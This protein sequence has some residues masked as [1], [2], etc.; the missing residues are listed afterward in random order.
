[1]HSSRSRPKTYGRQ[2][3]LLQDNLQDTNPT[4]S[5]DS[6]NRRKSRGS[7]GLNHNHN[8]TSNVTRLCDDDETVLPPPKIRSLSRGN[9]QLSIKASQELGNSPRSSLRASHEL[10]EA[11]QNHRFKDEIEYILDGL[12]SKDRVRV[13]QSCCIDLLRSMLKSEFLGLVKAYR[14]MDTIYD[15]IREDTNPIVVSSLVLMLGLVVKGSQAYREIMTLT[16]IVPFLC[17]N[18]D[19]DMDPMGTLPSSKV[20]VAM[21]NDF[22]DLARQSGMIM[23][24]QKVLAKSILLFTV[25]T[26][27]NEAVEEQDAEALAL[28]DQ[29]PDFYTAVIGI[30]VQDLAWIKQPSAS[31]VMTLSDVLDV[32]RI[33]CSLRILERFS[34][35]SKRPVTILAEQ[36][37]LCPLLVQLITLCRGHAFKFAQNTDSMN[38]MLHTLRLLINMT[39]DFEPCCK[40]L[41]KSDSITVLVQN[42]VQFYDHCRQVRIPSGHGEAHAALNSAVHGYSPGPIDDLPL[43]DKEDDKDWRRQ[44]QNDA[45]GWYDILLMSIGLLINMLETNADRRAQFTETSI[46]LECSATGDCIHKECLCERSDNVLERLV[47]VYNTEVTISETTD[48]RVLSAYLALLL[49]CIIDGIPAN[50]TRLYKSVNGNTLQPMIELLVEFSAMHH[51]VHSSL[52]GDGAAL[53]DG[54]FDSKEGSS[55]S[56][57][58]AKM[59]SSQPG[60]AISLDM[61]MSLDLDP[62]PILDDDAT[63]PRSTITFPGSKADESAKSFMKIIQV[64]KDVESRLSI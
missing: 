11:G 37:A 5:P 10:R 26:I 51:D 19:S 30:L 29:S 3:S 35:V 7:S 59:S 61:P 47:D 42:I 2:R 25:A 62:L 57:Q 49:G 54:L 63:P 60:G 8:G 6:S 55:S 21:Y 48:N 45:S 31:H 56:S 52:G 4:S 53:D 33:E 44:V 18:L 28:F 58:E 46:A 41:A 9:S 64:L 12:R 20:E 22:K 24:G 17:D 50:E 39:N 43:E 40:M 34:L 15:L 32:D 13:R 27:V 36:A 16:D 38:L 23:K 1:M 14:Y